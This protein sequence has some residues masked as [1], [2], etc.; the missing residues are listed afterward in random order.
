[1]LTA[2]CLAAGAENET[3][4][5]AAGRASACARW[6][7]SIYVLARDVAANSGCR[8]RTVIARRCWW[9]VISSAYQGRKY[10]PEAHPEHTRGHGWL[11]TDGS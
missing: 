8:W 7:L 1:M 5:G 11:L 4:L 2:E 10:A 9:I 6:P 3:L